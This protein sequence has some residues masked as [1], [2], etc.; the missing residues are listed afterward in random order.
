MHWWFFF[1]LSIYIQKS[2]L[3]WESPYKLMNV[4]ENCLVAYL[5]QNCF[6]RQWWACEHC[7]S[8][9]GRG[10]WVWTLGS[11]GCSKAKLWLLW[12]RW[13]PQHLAGHGRANEVCC[14]RETLG[15][16]PN[17]LCPCWCGWRWHKHLPTAKIALSARSLCCVGLAKLWA[18][19]ECSLHA[20][21]RD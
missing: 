7:L 14:Q 17:P 21:A 10:V 1:C 16:L 19:K 12:Y 8:H 18:P 6:W 11:R 5:L 4:Y 20:A 3:A 13:T 2:E 15:E 9:K